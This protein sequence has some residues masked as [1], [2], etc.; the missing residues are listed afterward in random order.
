MS[1]VQKF[2]FQPSPEFFI[3]RKLCYERLN[4]QKKYS[5]CREN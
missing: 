2:H 4:F 5:Q 1:F 3:K